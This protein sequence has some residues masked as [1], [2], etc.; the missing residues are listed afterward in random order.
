MAWLTHFPLPGEACL[1]HALAIQDEAVSLVD[2]PGHRPC[3]DGRSIL[4]LVKELQPAISCAIKK[5]TALFITGN[6]MIMAAPR[7]SSSSRS[8]LHSPMPLLFLRMV[9][10]IYLYQGIQKCGIVCIPKSLHLKR[11]LRMRSRDARKQYLLK[12]LDSRCNTRRHSPY[13]APMITKSRSSSIFMAG[14]MLCV[15]KRQ[16]LPPSSCPPRTHKQDHRT[17]V[18]RASETLFPHS[19]L[20]DML[21]GFSTPATVDDV[22]GDINDILSELRTLKGML[23][24]F[25][26]TGGNL[27]RALSIHTE[28]VSLVSNIEKGTAHVKA[29]PLPVS[30]EDGH[31]LLSL[32]K[33]VEPAVIQALD[34]LIAKKDSA[35]SITGVISILRHDLNNLNTSAIELE[36][37]MIMAA[38][39]HLVPEATALR[40]KV[41]AAAANAIAVFS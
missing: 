4:A 6:A 14:V 20:V 36:D 33:E 9:Y 1:I 35:L 27:L 13:D 32:S 23:D 37:A 17:V 31:S 38:P 39:A 26:T 15:G 7:P 21:P 10:I 19:R 28:A 30:E 2:R 25:P 41:D 8:I 29:L 3:Q 24:D 18:S 12:I 16:D 11:R 40:K 34:S 22:K 5:D